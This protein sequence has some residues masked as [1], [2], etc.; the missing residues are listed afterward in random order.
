MQIHDLSDEYYRLRAEHERALAMIATTPKQREAHL[1][2]A[3]KYLALA[4]RAE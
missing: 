3:E 2:M 1:R 4:S